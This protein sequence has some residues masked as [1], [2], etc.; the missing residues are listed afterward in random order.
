MSKRQAWRL[1]HGFL[2]SR[3]MLEQRSSRLFQIEVISMKQLIPEKDNSQCYLPEMILTIL[4]NILMHVEGLHTGLCHTCRGF[5][6][7][8]VWNNFMRLGIGQNVEP[9]PQ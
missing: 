6:Q 7:T 8:K 4:E 2:R 9:F 1:I 3:D 5:W